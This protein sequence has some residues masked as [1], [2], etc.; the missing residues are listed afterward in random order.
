MDTARKK[1]QQKPLWAEE[2][3]EQQRC[4]NAP[5]Q[6][7]SRANDGKCLHIFEK[8]PPKKNVNPP[9]AGNKP[10]GPEIA[11]NP[12]IC[13][14]NGQTSTWWE[15]LLNTQLISPQTL[16]K[17][18]AGAPHPLI[19]NGDSWITHLQKGLW[20][21]EKAPKKRL[22]ADGSKT[23]LEGSAGT[24][25]YLTFLYVPDVFFQE[26]RDDYH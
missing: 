1:K 16:S 7:S 19:Q 3:C 5:D 22:D 21:S 9:K 26:D 10:K 11:Q 17:C 18:G 23:T 13:D 6:G 20:I 12:E 8:E 14:C 25:V 15:T 24:G 4:R 2:L